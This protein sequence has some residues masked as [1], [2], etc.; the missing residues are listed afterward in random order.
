MAST[1]EIMISCQILWFFDFICN[2]YNFNTIRPKD[3]SHGS[4]TRSSKFTLVFRHMSSHW[5]PEL[6]YH[7]W[8]HYIPP[9]KTLPA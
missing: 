2:L 6:E 8:V 3:P 9:L 1:H 5:P 7:F 4:W